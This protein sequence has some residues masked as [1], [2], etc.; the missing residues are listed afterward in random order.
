MSAFSYMTVE[1][2]QRVYFEGVYDVYAKQTDYWAE[3]AQ[4]TADA[5]VGMHKTQQKIANVAR[6]TR[7]EGCGARS[8]QGDVCRYCGGER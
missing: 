7:C 8:W 4:N 1:H 3:M 5:A 2:A 6:T